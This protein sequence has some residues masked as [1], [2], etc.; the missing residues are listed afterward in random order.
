MKAYDAIVIGSGA[1]GLY[2]ALKLPRE[3]RIALLTKENL[4]LSSSQWAQGASLR[5]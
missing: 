3:W 2:T 5:S 4:T 1:A